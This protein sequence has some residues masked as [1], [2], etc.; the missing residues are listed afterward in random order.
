[1]CLLKLGKI[2][3]FFW[4]QNPIRPARNL[5]NIKSFIDIYDVTISRG[6]REFLLRGNLSAP[7]LLS[8]V[9][10]C[11][12]LTRI[13]NGPLSENATV[14]RW[15]SESVCGVRGKHQHYHQQEYG[16]GALEVHV[17]VSRRRWRFF[18]LKM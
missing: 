11:V 5:S 3:L 14:E 15:F 4:N 8:N 13:R 7:T 9:Y 12:R 17:E 16:Y 6:G 18:R 2:F 1:M 10:R